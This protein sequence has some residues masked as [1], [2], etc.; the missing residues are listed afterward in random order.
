MALEESQSLLLE[1]M[2]GR[3]RAFVTYLRPLL[4]KHYGAAGRNG[5][6]RIFTGT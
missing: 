4:E 2:V 5:P 6:R 3:S 1:M